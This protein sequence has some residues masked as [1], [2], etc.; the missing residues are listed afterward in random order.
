LLKFALLFLG[1]VYAF[2]GLTVKLAV[3]RISR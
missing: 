3:R 1:L 2:Y